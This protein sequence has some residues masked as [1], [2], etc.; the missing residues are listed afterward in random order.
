M[1][2]EKDYVIYAFRERTFS[3]NDLTRHKTTVGVS[4]AGNEFH[5]SILQRDNLTGNKLRSI[6]CFNKLS[7]NEL[8]T[9]RCV[10]D[11]AWSKTSIFTL[12]ARNK[13]RFVSLSISKEI[14]VNNL[15]K[16]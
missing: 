8:F 15:F 10:D 7:T 9:M 12:N 13:L 14:Y 11:L 1:V 16:K 5:F 3:V 4:Y 6:S 2:S